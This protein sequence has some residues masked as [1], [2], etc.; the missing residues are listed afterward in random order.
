MSDM[1]L[2]QGGNAVSTL[3]A[4]VESNIAANVGAGGSTNRRISIKGGAFREILNGKEVNISE[5]RSMNVVIIN[6]SKLSRMYFEGT[7]TEGVALKPT[8]WSSDSQ[9]P[10]PAVPEGQKQASKCADCKQNIKGSG[11]NG[12]RSCRF[13]QRLALLLEGNVEKKEVYQLT[14]PATSIFGD[15]EKGKLPL[16]GYVRYVTAHNTRVEAI[17][18]EM[19]FDT[20]SPT[21]KLVF[22]PVRALTDD[23]ARVVVEMIKAPETLKAITLNV[24]QMDGVIPAPQQA[25]FAP[26]PKAKVEPKAEPAPAEEVEEPKLKVSKKAAAPTDKPADLADVM[27]DWDD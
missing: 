8:C 17:V 3:F 27:A 2:F 5:E 19:R 9:T 25:L 1:T 22:K 26:E 15:G 13:Q 4:D 10:D 6:A 21:P 11:A 16:Q 12:G 18:T 24:S 7:Y 20:A 14:L 23:E